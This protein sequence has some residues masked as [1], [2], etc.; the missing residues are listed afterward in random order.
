VEMISLDNP[1]PGNYSIGVNGYMLATGG[2]QAYAVSYQ[3]DTLDRFT[4]YYPSRQDNHFSASPNLLR[5]EST[6]TA[7]SGQLEYSLNNG[8]SWQLVDNAIDLS[9]GYYEWQAPDTVSTALFRMNTVSGNFSSDT[10]TISE[11]INVYTG[12]DCPDSFLLYWDKV[13]GVNSYLVYTLGEKYMEPLRMVND[14][15]IILSKAGHPSLY[16][17]IAPVINNKT[18]LRSYGFNYTTQG[19]ECYIRSFLA[20]LLGQEVQLQLQL[21]TTYRISKIKWEKQ[22]N[23]GWMTLGEVNQVTGFNFNFTDNRLSQGMNSYRV[24]IELADGRVIYSEPVTIYFLGN[25]T[26]LVYPNPT[27]L[28]QP[29][30]LLVADEAVGSS[31]QIVN[32]LGQKV[33]QSIL[34][35]SNNSIAPDFLSAGLYILRIVRENG[36][37]ESV[38]LIVAGR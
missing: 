9:I 23:G 4:W 15:S 17:A 31:L 7:T 6:L 2:T 10:F 8:N 38:K 18:A 26:I 5:W 33:H 25:N 30:N 37:S 21:G 32:A 28:G 13:P 20:S 24:R 36:K 16:Y 14:T 29:I 27:R 34:Q 12:F 1:I 35:D 19:V 3:F 11:R 22:N